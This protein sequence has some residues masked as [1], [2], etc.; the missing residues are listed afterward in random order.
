MFLNS[1]THQIPALKVF[2]LVLPTLNQR[3]LVLIMAMKTIH[4]LR[5]LLPGMYEK[6]I[7][8]HTAFI[9]SVSRYAHMY[10]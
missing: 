2:G 4:A 8:W 1:V 7:L 10:I 3:Y 9:Q 6:E 5:L